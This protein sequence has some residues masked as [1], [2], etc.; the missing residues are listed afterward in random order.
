MLED[1]LAVLQ[2]DPGE[3]DTGE[4]SGNRYEIPKVDEF[5]NCPLNCYRSCSISR[6]SERFSVVT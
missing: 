4:D 2:T 3:G 6:A 5:H 1:E